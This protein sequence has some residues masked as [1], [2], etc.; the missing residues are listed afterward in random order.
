MNASDSELA[1]FN[2]LKSRLEAYTEEQKQE[3]TQRL[4]N[5]VKDSI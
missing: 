3:G 5:W 1:K 4:L 2:A